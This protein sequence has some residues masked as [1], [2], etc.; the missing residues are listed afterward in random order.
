MASMARVSVVGNLG[1][2]AE[3]KFISSGAAVLEF[4]I[5]H[6]QRSKEQGEWKETT[7]WYRVSFWG[8]RGEKI[9]PYLLKGKQVFV[10]GALTVREYV[11]KD[12][13]H[14]TSCEV[15]A[16]DVVLLGG[17]GEGGEGGGFSGQGQGGGYSDSGSD[18]G[19][20]QNDPGYSDNDV[21]F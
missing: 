3:L 1:R 14:G 13:R 20:S 9:K 5:A 21:P 6:N 10:T 18:R 8:N 12:G 7:V 19:S 11:T 15:R 16:D 4:S 2:D 17:R